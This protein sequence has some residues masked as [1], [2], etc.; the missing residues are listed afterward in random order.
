MQPKITGSSSRTQTGCSAAGNTTKSCFAGKFEDGPTWRERSRGRIRTND[1]QPRWIIDVRANKQRI[2][3]ENWWHRMWRAH[4]QGSDYQQNSSSS[5]SHIQ[6]TARREGKSNE[7]DHNRHEWNWQPWKS[8][9]CSNS[10][11]Y[12]WQCHYYAAIYI[13][14]RGGHQAASGHGQ[15]TSQSI[16]IQGS[17][18]ATILCHTES[19]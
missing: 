2:S 1:L 5:A 15:I 17:R 4:R 8:R 12:W 6:P 10:Q 9:N 14:A 18:F 16:C 7:C 11:A 13:N 3:C 19:L